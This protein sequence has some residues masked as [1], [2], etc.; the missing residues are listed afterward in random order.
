MTYFDSKTSARCY[1]AIDNEF[2][3]GSD[4]YSQTCWN[5]INHWV[6]HW[7]ADTSWQGSSSN[8]WSN[9]NWHAYGDSSIPTYFE[10]CIIPHYTHK[11]TAVVSDTVYSHSQSYYGLQAQLSGWSGAEI[12][13]P[14]D[15][16]SFR[17]EFQ[18]RALP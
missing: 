6:M 7:Q 8:I 9:I 17:V 10:W 1:T 11:T 18:Q 2:A 3:S 15:N 16:V 13:N 12:E 4:S 14:L 5:D